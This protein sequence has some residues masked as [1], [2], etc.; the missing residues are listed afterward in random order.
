MS[1]YQKATKVRDEAHDKARDKASL[2][3]VF[4]TRYGKQNPFFLSVT[5]L[6]PRFSGSHANNAA[7]MCNRDRLGHIGTEQRQCPVCLWDHNNKPRKGSSNFRCGSRLCQNYFLAA[8]TKY[9]IEKLA[10][11]ATM[12]RPRDLPDSI[13]AQLVSVSAF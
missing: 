2:S 1:Y 4:L 12:I 13:V 7:A 11:A 6:F 10:F 8:E 9:K 3:V 5:M